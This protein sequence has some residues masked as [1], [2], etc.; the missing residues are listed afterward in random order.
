MSVVGIVHPPRGLVED[1]CHADTG[2]PIVIAFH[3]WAVLEYGARERVVPQVRPHPELR[4][5]F[6]QRNEK[7]GTLVAG[8]SIVGWPPGRRELRRHCVEIIMVAMIPKQ[9]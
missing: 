6:R 8:R 9:R 1:P 2:S 4:I 3:E 7:F 5:P